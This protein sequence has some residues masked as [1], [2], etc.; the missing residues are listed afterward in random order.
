[1]NTAR[2]RVD[3]EALAGNYLALH[4][5]SAGDCAGVVKADGYGLGVA[6]VTQTLAAVGCRVF[7]VATIAEALELRRLLA[8][9]HMSASSLDQEA[10]IVVLGGLSTAEGAAAASAARIEPVL[11][12]LHQAKLWHPYRDQPATLHIDTGMERLGFQPSELTSVDWT[13]YRLVMVMTHLACADVPEHPLNV[14]QL[15]RFELARRQLPAQI[16]QLPTSIANSAGCLLPP[17][18]HGDL[19]R[20][21]IGLYGGH[22]QNQILDNPLQAVVHMHG[23]VVQRQRLSVG[24][25]V[26]YGATFVTERPTEI[27]IVGLGYADGLPRVLSNIGQVSINGKRAPIVGRVSMDVVHVDV[28][29]LVEP[30]NVGDWVEFLGADISVDEVAQWAGTIGLEVLCSLGRRPIWEYQ[31]AP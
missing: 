31:N 22:P 16:A 30:P 2:I 15:E 23:Q 28:T 9:Q 26:G 12:N 29:D 10:R 3:L 11:N 1:M 21:G 5:R 27:A 19:S 4:E 18:W 17:R 25:S 6:R 8:D 24:T 20:P 14:T 7:C 13:V